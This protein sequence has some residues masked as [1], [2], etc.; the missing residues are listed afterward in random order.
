MRSRST[1]FSETAEAGFQPLPVSTFPSRVLAEPLHGRL[2]LGLQWLRGRPLSRLIRRLQEWERLGAVDFQRL[3]EQRLQWMLAYARAK[4]PLYRTGQWQNALTGPDDRLEAWPVLERDVL[5]ERFD[6]LQALPARPWH[7]VERTSGSTGAQIRISMTLRDVTWRW[8]QRYRALMWHGIPIGVR[9]LRISHVVRPLRDRVLGQKNVPRA[10][11]REALVEAARFLGNERPGLVFGPPS[12]LFHL[13]RYLREIDAGGPMARF[14]RVGGE[15]LYPFQRLE[16]EGSL[17]E[18]VVDSYGCTEVGPVASECPAGSLHVLG[19]QVHVEILRGDAP[20]ESGEFGNIVLTSLQN[21]AMPLIRCRIGDRGRLSPD[22]C[23]CGLPH[24]VLNDLQARAGDTFLAA[25]GAPRHVS[26]LVGRLGVF[27]A[28]P[29]SHGVRQILFGQIDPLA[30]RA[31]VEVGRL[32]AMDG[33]NR[34][35][36]EESLGRLIR[37]ACGPECAVETRFAET[38]PREGGKH[39]YYR[40][41]NPGDP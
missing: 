25:D 6:H 2:Y 11:P 29:V 20:V 13:A 39:R 37:D 38:I 36:I 27:F 4:T 5:A 34:I 21:T 15:Q 3:H 8:A 17:A 41:E 24:P 7:V 33:E 1:S 16:I 26:W 22:P 23:G 12:A 19:E 32:S 35:R 14:A 28:D 18:R 40:V 30:W 9:T 10:L 31:W